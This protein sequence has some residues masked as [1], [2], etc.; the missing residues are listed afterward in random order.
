MSKVQ[1]ARAWTVGKQIGDRSG[2][3]R[4]FRAV[5]EDGEKAAIKFVPKQP[6]AARELLFVELA[7]VPNV[8][9]VLDSGETEGDYVL[10]MPLADRSLRQ[11]MVAARGVLDPEETVAVLR[12]VVSALVGI[13]K[14]VVHRDLKPENVLLLNGEWC[15]ADFGIARYAEASTSQDTHKYAMTAAYAAPE[16]WRFEHASPATD[17]YSV[18][19]MSYEMLTG[20]LPFPGPTWDDFR[21]QH[22]TMPAPVIAGAPPPIA[23]LVAECMVKSPEARPTPINLAGRLDR[24]FAPASPA[25]AA[26]QEANRRALQERTA[27]E[28]SAVAAQSEADRRTRLFDACRESLNAIGDRLKELVRENAPGVAVD[29]TSAA[30][31]WALKLRDATLAM[32]PA[33]PAGSNWGGFPV[34]FDV[35]AY[36]TIAVLVPRTG[37]DWEGRSHSLWFCDSQELGVYRWYELGF[38]TNPFVGRQFLQR[39]AAMEPGEN[40]GKALW[41][42]VAEYQLA[43]GFIPIDQGDEDAFFDRWLQWFADAAAGTLQP[44]SSM[45]ERGQ[46]QSGWRR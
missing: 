46:P 10:V 13:E 26:L 12:G 9:P 3:G 33:R 38:M 39:P 30:D 4:V 25:A 44:P 6:G 31:W 34:A 18:G 14:R 17:V 21:Q 1:L 29:R 19:V 7:G 28:A 2:F 23:S 42:G 27:A 40:S 43:Y 36:A 11:H 22:L 20:V 24:A 37:S 35:L 41:Q 45:P 15:L 5:G 8:I 32:D 16:R